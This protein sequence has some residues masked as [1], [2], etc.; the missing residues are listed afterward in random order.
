MTLEI[1]SDITTYL[2]TLWLFLTLSYGRFFP[3]TRHPF[4]HD[5]PC[6][7]PLSTET[8]VRKLQEIIKQLTILYAKITCLND[9]HAFENVQLRERSL[10][11]NPSTM[12]V[13]MPST[14]TKQ[15][16]KLPSINNYSPVSSGS[17]TNPPNSLFMDLE[18]SRSNESWFHSDSDSEFEAPSVTITDT[19]RV[20]LVAVNPYA[21][22]SLH[23]LNYIKR[24]QQISNPGPQSGIEGNSL[25]GEEFGVKAEECP[26]LNLEET[27]HRSLLKAKDPTLMEDD[28]L[29]RDG[30]Q[31]FLSASSVTGHYSLEA[32]EQREISANEEVTLNL[33]EHPEIQVSEDIS[34]RKTEAVLQDGENSEFTA[35][36]VGMSSDNESVVS[37]KSTCDGYTSDKL[38]KQTASILNVSNT[39]E[40]QKTDE[41][42]FLSAQN[43]L[44]FSE[45]QLLRKSK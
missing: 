26:N 24:P 40:Q 44:S 3:S 45:R 37:W 29:S 21:M 8:E 32:A 35:F 6:T 38:G 34:E 43:Y 18:S 16:Q 27:S 11:D 4:K 13:P 23:S 14:P 5:Q 19:I 2:P 15:F 28:S 22:E 12:E 31:F 39:S 30:E 1:G 7:L 33:E 25:N 10:P 9:V 42:K 36:D 17:E 20:K 41:Q